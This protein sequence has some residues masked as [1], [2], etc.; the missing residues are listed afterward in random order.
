MSLLD[1]ELLS[2]LCNAHKNFY[3]RSFSFAFYIC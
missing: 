2:E 3:M 1:L